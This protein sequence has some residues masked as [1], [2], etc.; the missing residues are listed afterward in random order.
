MKG[1]AIVLDDVFMTGL[2]HLSVFYQMTKT[3]FLGR[4]AY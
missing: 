2:Y 1:V 4:Q 3:I